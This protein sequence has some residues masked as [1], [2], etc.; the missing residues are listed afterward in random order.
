[1]KLNAAEEMLQQVKGGRL[2]TGEGP[3]VLK[4][5]VYYSP[6]LR[7]GHGAHCFLPPPAWRWAGPLSVVFIQQVKPAPTE[8]QGGEG[9]Q[10][11]PERNNLL[12]R[13]DRSRVALSPG[14]RFKVTLL[15]SSQELQGIWGV[16]KSVSF[17]SRLFPISL[18]P[19]PLC[20]VFFDRVYS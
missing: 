15:F 17:S 1:M 20:V 18:L 16:R 9:R 19:S 12:G 11:W 8:L 10:D 5:L 7:P 13:L 14:F 2:R 6:A 3:R 4:Q